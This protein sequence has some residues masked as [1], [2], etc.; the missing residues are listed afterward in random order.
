MQSA[1]NDACERLSKTPHFEAWTP[2]RLGKAL[3]SHAI[4]SALRISSG[5][6][7]LSVKPHTFFLIYLVSCFFILRCDL[8][9]PPEQE[10][11]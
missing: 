9:E 11:F 8:E 2:E 3:W 5:A 1:L 7:T 10:A 4:S 6:P